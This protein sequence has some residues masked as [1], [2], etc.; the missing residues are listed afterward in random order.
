M[1]SPVLEVRSISKHF[2]ATHALTGVSLAFQPGC[3]H[4]VVGENGA[5]KTTLMNLIG[6]V[7]Q[8][9]A[10]EIILAGERVH[11]HDPN[12]ALRMGIGFVHQEITL[13]QHLSVAENV[14]MHALNESGRPLVSFAD[15]Q[16]RTRALLTDFD[17]R[18]EFNAFLHH[19]IETAVDNRLVKFEIRDTET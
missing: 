19:L 7:H 2:G 15:I 3:V 10:G 16:A 4:A 9:D 8:P 12:D 5:G 14:S 18:L 6:G 1:A 17:T 11:I 13:C